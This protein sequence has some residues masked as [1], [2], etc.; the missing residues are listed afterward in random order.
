MDQNNENNISMEEYDEREAHPERYPSKA[1]SVIGKCVKYFFAALAAVVF[2]VMIWRINTMESTPGDMKV[3]SV[4]QATYDAYVAAQQRG[5]KL[6]MFTQVKLDPVTT[7]DEAY[8]YFWVADS[9]V[10]PDAQQL[11]LVV[12]YNKSTL[13][14]LASDFKLGYVP[15]RDEEVL[16]V[17][18]R[19]IEDATPDDPEDNEEESAW[20][21]HTLTPTGEPRQGRRDVYNYR[22]YI[23]DGVSVDKNTIGVI[24]DFYYVGAA[25][26][27]SPLGSLYVYYELAESE[28]VK[29][30]KKDVAAMKEFGAK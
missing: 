3:L 21:V 13:E 9:V 14:H 28:S 30:T 23:F 1:M 4:N 2:A 11:Q 17:R 19:V 27:E 25:D 12:R 6:E 24:V 10:I 26:A 18:L 22:R 7:N 29:L 8:G 16:S 20:I 5:E 15:S